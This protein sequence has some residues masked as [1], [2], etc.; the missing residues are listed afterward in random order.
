MA[1]FGDL[2]GDIEETQ[3]TQPLSGYSSSIQDPGGNI[4]TQDENDPVGDEADDAEIPTALQEAMIRR[5]NRAY[6]EEVQDDDSLEKNEKDAIDRIDY[7]MLKQIWI[8][9][10]NTSELCRY[11]EELIEILLDLLQE[12]EDNLEELQEQGRTGADPTL[13]NIAANICKMDMD[14]LSFVISDLMRIRLEKIEKYYIHNRD[15]LD[16]MSQR[17]VSNI[18][19]LFF[20][21]SLGLFIIVSLTTLSDAIFAD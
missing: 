15:F 3:P 1:D 14:R 6:D 12:N 16:R 21:L 18:C 17:E 10:L 20:S 11:N 19:V 2:L 9:E 4:E 7:Q 8:Q 5:E 13:S